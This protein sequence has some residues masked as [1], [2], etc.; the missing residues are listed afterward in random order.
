MLSE[1]PKI[2]S[3]IVRREVLS[4]VCGEV[5]MNGPM[6]GRGV[7]NLDERDNLSRQMKQVRR[8]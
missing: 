7:K 4:L 1:I 6:G 2:P 8:A 5:R 3:H